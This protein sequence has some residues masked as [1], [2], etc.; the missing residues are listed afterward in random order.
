MAGRLFTDYF[1]TD[2]IKDADEWRSSVEDAEEF[3]TFREGVSQ[4]YEAL[5]RFENPNEAVTEQELIRPVLQLLGWVDYLPQQG[6]A[7]KEDIPDHLLLADSESKD[8]ATAERN[9]KHRFRHATVVQ[10]SKRFGLPLDKRQEDDD[11]RVRTPHGQILRYLLTAD[12]ESEANIRW[13]V[14]TNGKVWRLYDHRARYPVRFPGPSDDFPADRLHAS[15]Q[16][17]HVAAIQ[18]R[19]NRRDVFHQLSDVVR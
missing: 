8:R 10:E 13:G 9:P 17:R 5:C 11:V 19:W 12:V 15:L 6:S 2:G 18:P 1:L 14:L 3:A 7:G 16:R 4:R